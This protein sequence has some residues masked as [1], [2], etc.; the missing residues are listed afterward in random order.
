MSS[1]ELKRIAAEFERI[2]TGYVMPSESDSSCIIR[3]LYI[4]KVYRKTEKKS[5]YLFQEMGATA[6]H[7]AGGQVFRGYAQIALLSGTHHTETEVATRGVRRVVEPTSDTTVI[8][9]VAPAAAT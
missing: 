4:E 1:S 7:L 8:S 9:I 2:V 5:P 6:Y 3:F